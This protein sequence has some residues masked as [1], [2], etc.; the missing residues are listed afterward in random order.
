MLL[1]SSVNSRCSNLFAKMGA[2]GSHV[3]HSL[4]V[5]SASATCLFFGGGG[6]V[7]ETGIE[8]IAQTIPE[9]VEAEDHKR[10]CGARDDRGPRRLL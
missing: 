10:D 2:D 6:G 8:G 9:Q 3:A 5:D 7:A 4:V 1:D